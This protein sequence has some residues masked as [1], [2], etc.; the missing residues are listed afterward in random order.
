MNTN[1]NQ[2]QTQI[3]L[4]HVL[5]EW[6]KWILKRKKFAT[7]KVIDNLKFFRSSKFGKYKL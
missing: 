6:D 1:Q 3:N 5:N 4:V 2:T 7:Y